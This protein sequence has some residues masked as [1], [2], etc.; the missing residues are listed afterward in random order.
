[1]RRSAGPIP[2]RKW[3]SQSIT[4]SP[5]SPPESRFSRGMGGFTKDSRKVTSCQLRTRPETLSAG[6][7]VPRTRYVPA[8]LPKYQKN[9][10]SRDVLPA[11][12]VRGFKEYGVVR[13]MGPRRW[14]TTS[15]ESRS[16]YGKTNVHPR[17]PIRLPPQP[18]EPRLHHRR[19]NLS[20]ML[21]LRNEVQIFAGKHVHGAAVEG[22]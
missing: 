22:I 5:P 8:R 14:R 6:S 7:C 16:A 12:I 1:M 21:R 3:Q 2:Q 11:G 20:G 10:A 18:P 17:F 19:P 4:L 15:V 9:T 13:Q